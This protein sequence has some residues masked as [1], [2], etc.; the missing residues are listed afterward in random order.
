MKT[1]KI[2]EALLDLQRQR[3]LIE[4]AIQG[5]QAILVRL[6]GQT[7][8]DVFNNAGS[9]RTDKLSYVDATVQILE[10]AGRPMHVKKIWEQ[11]KV[12]RGDSKIKRQSV[13]STL[14]R[15]ISMKGD[16]A[17]V[18]KLSPGIYALTKRNQP[19]AEVQKEDI[20]F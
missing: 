12:L 5:L 7:T 2:R 18:K 1:D 9:L 10:A 15:H 14:L 20:S 17:K 3:D 16:E 11:I 19:V 8:D 4:N 6:N 13:E